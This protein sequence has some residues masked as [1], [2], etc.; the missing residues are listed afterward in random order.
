MSELTT[1]KVVALIVAQCKKIVA[2][3]SSG[4]QDVKWD[5]TTHSL[6]FTLTSGKTVSVPITASASGITY[7][8]A[9]SK[10]DAN[11][12]QSAIDEVL[13]KFK[14]EINDLGK[15]TAY[16]DEQNK[17][18]ELNSFDAETTFN[19]AITVNGADVGIDNGVVLITDNTNGKDIV[20]QYSADE[21]VISTNGEQDANTLK[22]PLENGT[23]VTSAK[24]DVK[25][26]V[27]KNRDINSEK[28]D[29][30]LTGDADAT[31]SISHENGTTNTTMSVGKNYAQISSSTVSEKAENSNI[32]LT[33]NSIDITSSQNQTTEGKQVK[34]SIT[35]ENA[36]INQKRVATEDDLNKKLDKN[37]NPSGL[38]RVYGIKKDGS[39]TLVSIS[40]ELDNTSTNLVQ[41]NTI[42]KALDDKLNV[43]APGEINRVYVRKE[44]NLDSSLPFVYSAEGSSI[45]YRNA[46]GQTQ[47]ETPS[48][49][50]D[51]T[52]KKYVDEKLALKQD[53]LTAGS[54][55]VIEDNNTIKSVTNYIDLIGEDGTLDNDQMNMLKGD[56]ATVLRRSGIL[57][58][59]QGK[60]INGS[61]D[62]TFVSPYYS[63]PNGTEDLSAYIIV[64]KQDRTWSSKIKKIPSSDSVVLAQ[65]ANSG[66]FKVYGCTSTNS[67]D[68]CI[69]SMAP[70]QQAV[71]RFTTR[72]TLQTNNPTQPLDCINLQSL[73]NVGGHE[74]VY[75]GEV[76]PTTEIG[77][78]YL[79]K[80]VFIQKNKSIYALEKDLTHGTLSW[81]LKNDFEKPS[82][83]NFKP[84]D[85][86]YVIATR[87]T[88]MSI[89]DTFSFL[90]G[91]KL[92]TDGYAIDGFKNCSIVGTK[93]GNPIT[94][95]GNILTSGIYGI[96]T[97]PTG[98]L[99][100]ATTNLEGFTVT[101]SYE[102]LW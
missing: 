26:S 90:N 60:P 86:N 24:F 63:S 22:F 42:K 78:K 39:S 69:A 40:E 8:N 2:Q 99:K 92:F 11:D 41:N 82:W 61:G 74:Q 72:S 52:N 87:A 94:F 35:P 18:T 56:D 70:V 20:T 13:T 73:Q 84:T 48:Q 4:I 7:S 79:E 89:D 67:N 58:S 10:L 64:V 16:L 55:I 38:V 46:S 28:E 37:T 1:G 95:T 49:E 15:K 66:Q 3:Q 45:V 31:L 23:L 51:A 19:N 43:F 57:Y 29:V 33:S 47:V 17:F 12:V 93:D 62:Y 91:A 50:K 53:K 80:D 59:M 65:R 97:T 77:V 102:Y 76:L 85:T 101:F 14:K 5:T 54:R 21:I 100:A 36:T 98:L 30:W 81:V 83:K 96:I 68:V 9:I 25:H 32:T 75:F 71:A 6:V 44:N 34:L 27:I 88:I